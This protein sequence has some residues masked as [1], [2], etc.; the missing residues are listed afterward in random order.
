MAIK[1]IAISQLY[2]LNPLLYGHKRY[3]PTFWKLC[4]FIL[5]TII[6]TNTAG[7]EQFDP[8][9]ILLTDTDKIAA[10]KVSDTIDEIKN[11]NQLP[12]QQY[13]PKSN[14]L[15][16]SDNNTLMTKAVNFL[17]T[18]EEKIQ[19]SPVEKEQNQISA[20]KKILIE[21]QITAPVVKNDSQSKNVLAEMIDK[22]RSVRLP[23]KND[24]DKS[25]DGEKTE[26]ITENNDIRTDKPQN[27]AAEIFTQPKQE[28]SPKIIISDETL[29][30]LQDFIERPEETQNPLL[31][32]EVL[33]L[34]GYNK[35]AA[36]FYFEALDRL[37]KEGTLSIHDKAWLLLQT[38]G[39]LKDTDI[40]QASTTYKEVFTQCPSS[41]WAPVAKIQS[42]LLDWMQAEKPYELIEKCKSELTINNTEWS[43][44]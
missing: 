19:N 8:T 26:T 12:S 43:I 10:C 23:P 15:T 29:T 14:I 21:A 24:S 4:F 25:S 37:K 6:S 17:S 33:F 39:C 18:F 5:L 1:R 38:A 22:I 40:R 13:H 28:T 35:Q 41:T 44:D 36:I 9:D 7:S 42:D 3:S 11:S 27:D 30:E 2:Y 31:L 20:A 32:A 16:A 34:S